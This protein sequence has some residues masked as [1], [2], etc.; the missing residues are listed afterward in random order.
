MQDFR[1]VHT[2]AGGLAGQPLAASGDTSLLVHAAYIATTRTFAAYNL[3]KELWPTQPSKCLLQGLQRRRMRWS[4]ERGCTRFGAQCQDPGTL[5][6]SDAA[7]PRRFIVG[8]LTPLTHA[9]Q[10]AGGRVCVRVRTCRRQSL[11]ARTDAQAWRSLGLGGLGDDGLSCFT[12]IPG[13]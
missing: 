2:L 9:R 10:R 5:W 11:L 1:S 13:R 6:S 3:P 12:W 7:H 8:P 4:A